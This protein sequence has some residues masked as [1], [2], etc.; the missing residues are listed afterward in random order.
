MNTGCKCLVECCK[1]CLWGNGISLYD[2][3]ALNSEHW[4]S[5]G[6]LGDFLETVHEI[7]S[8]SNDPTSMDIVSTNVMGSNLIILCN[9]N[10]IKLSGPE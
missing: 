8:T 10:L 5:Q 1:D 6:L 9:C 3:N 4:H 7:L 2:T